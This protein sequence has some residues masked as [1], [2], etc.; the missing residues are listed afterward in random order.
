MSVP[1]KHGDELLD[2]L[3][4][5][6]PEEEQVPVPEH[7]LT[8]Y[9]SIA[10]YL[11]ELRAD[12]YRA[13][14]SRRSRSRSRAS[15]ANKHAQASHWQPFYS[16]VPSLVDPRS[17][18][19]ELLRSSFRRE[20]AK[21][22]NV[23]GISIDHIHDVDH[24]YEPTLEPVSSDLWTDRM[25][26]E[27]C[28]AQVRSLGATSHFYIGI[29]CS[30]LTR[31]FDCYDED[32]QL[33]YKG[34]HKKWRSMYL[35]CGTTGAEAAKLEKALI[36]EFNVQDYCMNSYSAKGGERRGPKDEISFVYLCKNLL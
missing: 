19:L 36:D 28:F 32:G 6:E 18:K 22:K 1:S 15:T 5:S 31:F 23:K 33:V 3:D 14:R 2:M 8:R 11:P 16:S 4:T 12:R 27:H 17:A 9:R 13:V 29:C 25:V 26:W 34:H 24:V 7:L 30:P 20:C 35:L 10:N 21:A